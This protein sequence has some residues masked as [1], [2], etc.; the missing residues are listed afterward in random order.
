MLPA[1]RSDGRAHP[2][3]EFD[4]PQKDDAPWLDCMDGIKASIEDEGIDE[5]TVLPAGDELSA[6]MGEP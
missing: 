6:I 3:A 5:P 4:L 2:V 1:N